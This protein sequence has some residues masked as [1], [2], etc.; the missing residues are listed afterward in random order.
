MILYECVLPIFAD[1]LILYENIRRKWQD[2]RRIP[3]KSHDTFVKVET[4]PVAFWCLHAKNRTVEYISKL[5]IQRIRHFVW[6]EF[7]IEQEYRLVLPG[8][9]SEYVQ[10]VK[11]N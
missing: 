9:E 1:V 5:S 11:E 3:N 2:S 8:L 10:N 7:R 4:K 6:V